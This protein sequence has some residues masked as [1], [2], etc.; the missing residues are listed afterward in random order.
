MGRAQRSAALGFIRPSDL[1]DARVELDELTGQP[2]HNATK[3]VLCL[4]ADPEPGERR[5]VGLEGPG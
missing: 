4:D 2:G 1:V 5:G 3:T